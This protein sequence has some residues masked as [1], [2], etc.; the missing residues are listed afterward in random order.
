MKG[1]GM[2]IRN[3]DEDLYL[4]FP[5]WQGSGRTNELYT[6]AMTLY[7]SLKQTLP[8]A[9][10]HVESMAELQEE[11]DIVGYAQI[12]DHLQQVRALLIDRNPRRIFSIGGD[13][14]I[15]IAQ[16][17]FLNKLHDGDMALIW[18]DAHADA[19]TPQSSPSHT[20][21]GMVLRTL[22]GDGDPE[23]ISQ[24]FSSLHPRQV[25]LAGVRDLDPPEARF[26][27][28]QNLASFTCDQLTN[29]VQNLITAIQARGFTHIYL[30]IDVDV[31]DPTSFPYL[32]HPTPNGLTVEA[33]THVRQS[34]IS[35]FLAIGGS[36][37]EF[38]SLQG[39]TR[40]I[41]QLKGLYMHPHLLQR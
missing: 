39:D 38:T 37:V 15:E 31:L 28:Q 14:G 19:N 25:F 13:C 27:E 29:N 26:V 2:A 23:V 17:S 36:V 34:L 33:L 4:L 7:Q 24:S 41:S 1:S 11:H 3:T 8:F 21:H 9:Q 18:L 32:K 12:I 22:L 6:G 40:A 16:V 30:H 20:F 35:T 5:Q 10:V